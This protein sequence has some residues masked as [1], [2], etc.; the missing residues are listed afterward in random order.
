MI[1][2][3]ALTDIDETPSSRFRIR[4]LIPA[5]E[6]HGLAVTD[7][8]RS[9]STQLSGSRFGNTRIRS[10]PYKAAMAVAYHLADL[11]QTLSRVLT[12]RRF[13]ATWV[14]RE[15]V[16]GHPSWECLLKQPIYYDID[17]AIFLKSKFR[18]AGIDR[19]IREAAYVFAGNSFLTDYCSALT[20][21]I[22]L[23]PT[24]VDTSRF[25][26]DPHWH[27]SDVFKVVWSG[28]S[29]SFPYLKEIEEPLA[30]FFRTAQD[31]RLFIYSNRNPHE[32]TALRDFIH[33]EPWSVQAEVGQIQQADVGLMP[34]PDTDWARGKC[35]YKMLL[36]A[37]CGVPC[38]VSDVGM[39]TE[40]LAKGRVGIGCRTLNDWRLGLEDL[41]RQ[42]DRLRE[43]YSNGPAVVQRHYALNV[44]AGKIARAM[45]GQNDVA[46]KV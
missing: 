38:L 36:Y 22:E 43:T 27:P 30:A 28:T 4:S 45:G 9:F 34:I 40:V 26:P 5:L 42:R 46:L 10:D 11:G 12:S 32:L 6:C 21:R 2:V 13:S 1:D 16:I 24:S 15:V 39:N 33:F 7:L 44:V 41:Y 17:D 35:S 14:S 19:L 23:V 3:A 25:Y 29:S 37:A 18:R 31:A 8:K 20:D